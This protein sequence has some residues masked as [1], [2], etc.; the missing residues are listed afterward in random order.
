MEMRVKTEIP[1]VSGDIP[2]KISNNPFMIKSC[3]EEVPRTLDDD[4]PSILCSTPESKVH[5]N[6]FSKKR[7]GSEESIDEQMSEV[8]DAENVDINLVTK[9][10]QESVNSKLRK[11]RAKN[12]KP[13]RSNHKANEP[14]ANTI[15]NFFS[16]V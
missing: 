3:I 10:S 8:I 1:M 7:K 16:R 12:E 9:G 15:L 5:C 4:E 11:V 2:Q 6:I 14:K 13:K